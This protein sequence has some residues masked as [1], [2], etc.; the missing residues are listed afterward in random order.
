MKKAFTLIE[1]LVVIAV[2][3]I[4]AALLMPALQKAKESARRAACKTNLH[5]V[6]IALRSFRTDHNERWPKHLMLELMDNLNVNVWGR[7]YGAEYMDDLE[8]FWCPST[9]NY[10][11]EV[12]CAYGRPE[13]V[14][15][16][17][18][19]NGEGDMTSIINSSYGY[20][21]ARI[22]DNADPARAISV[23]NMETHWRAD[24]VDYAPVSATGWNV[25]AN[26]PNAN[27]EMVAEGTH[28]VFVDVAVMWEDVKGGTK[29][30]IPYQ[31]HSMPDGT[32]GY[33]TGCYEGSGSGP[34]W[35]QTG[36]PWHMWTWPNDDKWHEY[37]SYGE[38]KG[39]TESNLYDFVRAG[40]VMNP[41]LD[42]DFDDVPREF[43]DRDTPWNNPAR[44][45]L[46]NWGP[47]FAVGQT[48]LEGGR[49]HG[50]GWNRLCVI[51]V[52]D[53]FACETDT[54][55]QWST[56]GEWQFQTGYKKRAGYYEMAMD[57]AIE[58]SKKDAQILP[59]AGFRH[60]IGLADCIRDIGSQTPA[61]VPYDWT[62]IPQP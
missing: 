62:E 9:M 22:A 19:G 55:A 23:D 61:D 35:C 6:G 50:S 14:A 58:P 18:F 34:G 38:V 60:G 49:G 10:L 4:L 54:P 56:Y 53:I 59:L 57:D 32:T 17:G 36:Y 13:I 46:R 24:V 27:R 25:P 30:W 8:V 28:I 51:D 52:D 37:P 42:E 11:R 1:L 12:Q 5:N 7:L 3:A 43:D 44:N 48:F 2:I 33:G 29:Y 20:D 41:R 26:H 39:V 16:S 47:E 45:G 40:I 31:G 15:W 21:N